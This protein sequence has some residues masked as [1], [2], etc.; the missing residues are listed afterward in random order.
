MNCI[1]PIPAAIIT[2][3]ASFKKLVPGIFTVIHTFGRDMKMNPHFHVSSTAGG[4]SLDYQKWIPDFFIKHDSV[5]RMW[6]VEVLK[7]FRNLYQQGKLELPPQLKHFDTYTKFNTWLDF[8]FE[9]SWVVHLQ[10]KSKSHNH[11]VKYVGRYLKRPPI[12]ETRITQY[13]DK[14]V[15]F[16]YLSHHTKQK[17]LVTLPISDFIANLV[18]HIPDNNF[19]LIRYYNWLSNRNRSKLLPIVYKLVNH[20]VVPSIKITWRSLYKSSFGI[21]PLICS[22]CQITMT[23]YSISTPT[24]ASLTLQHQ[25]LA[26]RS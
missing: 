3:L 23:L 5:K 15:T 2:K 20:Q 24:N 10:K 9:K 17:T 19:R 25:T 14:N 22:I 11:N 7:V 1:V 4:L 12:A 26:T 18:R 6:K 21:D 13:D 16:Y 8:L